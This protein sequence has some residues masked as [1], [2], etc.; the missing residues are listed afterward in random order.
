MA[1]ALRIEYAGAVYH[2]M[3]RGN[4]GREIFADDQDR[5]R[6]LDTIGEASEKTGWRIH[7]YVL[8]RVSQAISRAAWNPGKKLAKLKLKLLELEKTE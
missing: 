2:L 5:Q 3:A 4:Q 8:S 1:R 6:L 7:A